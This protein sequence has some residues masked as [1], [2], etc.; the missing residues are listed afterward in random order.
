MT[1]LLLDVPGVGVLPAY[2]S[3]AHVEDG[4]AAPGVVVLHEAF[5]LTDDIRRIAD[6]FAARGFHAVAPDLLSY[7]GMV[8]CLV[9]LVRA[10]GA[11]EGR[12]FAEIDAARTWLAD[13]EDC[14]GQVGV[15]GFCLGGAFALVMAN[16]GFGASAAQYGRLPKN[17]DAAMTG[18]C[19]V[20]ASYGALDGTLRGA[21]ATLTGALE[22]TGVEHDV[23]EYADAGHSFMNHSSVP[24]WMA[25][26]A[27]SMH[28]GYVD[29]AATD[30]WD[31]ITR[32]FDAALR[33][34]D[35]V[36]SS[37]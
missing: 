19:P 1:E 36:A 13:R 34:Q 22:R 20:V 23:I 16:R 29:T 17:L 15:A 11:G 25:P 3:P 28:A 31:R 6:E 27:R 10:L 35:D 2:F 26:F 7:G 21:A 37:S 33:P 30:A 8:R 14:T 5:G 9:T 24:G 12:P 4:V 32:M 18:A